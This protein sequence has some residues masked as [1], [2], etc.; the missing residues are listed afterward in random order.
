MNKKAVLIITILIYGIVATSM[1]LGMNL[2]QGGTLLERI[3][4]SNNLP[5]R[6]SAQDGLYIPGIQIMGVLILS[7]V[8]LKYLYNG[9]ATLWR[10]GILLVVIITA[11]IWK[12]FVL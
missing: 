5:V 7:W 12:L 4:V 8:I 3:L 10:N 2:P 1:V 6:T 11:G 9:K